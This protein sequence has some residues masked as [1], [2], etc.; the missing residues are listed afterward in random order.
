MLLGDKE[1]FALECYHEPL[2]N[3]HRRV[4]GRM[5]VWASGW[6]LGDISE[7]ACMLNVAEGHLSRVVARIDSLDDPVLRQL[8]DRDAFDF[9]DRTLYVDDDRSGEQV[10]R[11]AER[12]FKFDFL[13]NGGG[14]FDETKSFI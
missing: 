11:D 12:F 4:F 2:R 10:A 7:P 3:E 8:N 5:C 13:T 6:Q 1:G 14:S 9:L